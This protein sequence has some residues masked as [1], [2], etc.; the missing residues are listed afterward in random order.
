M[1]QLPI[2]GIPACRIELKGKP[3]HRVA[4]KYIDGLGKAT[5]CIPLMVPAFGDIEF[6]DQIIARL[7]GLLLTGS[8]SNVEPHRYDGAQSRAGTAHDPYRDGT[9]L[10]LIRAAVDAGVPVF[11]VCRGIQ[12]LNVALGG[13]LHQNIHELPGKN[14]HRMNRAA[15]NDDRFTVRHSIDI[16]PGGVLSEITGG[17]EQEMVNSLHAQAIDRLADELVV[18][19]TSDDGVIEAVSRKGGASFVL[20]V[21][22]HPEYP[23]SEDCVL[24]RK[25][26]AAFNAAAQRHLDARQNTTDR[27]HAA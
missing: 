11:A 25:L 20:G 6:A 7:D 3:A 21:Q 27:I 8:G 22:W 14:E 16:R 15:E 4:G 9:S 10:P 2:I 17:A 5:D 18:E 26:F 1:T 12:E 23:L 19:A 13:S 24:A